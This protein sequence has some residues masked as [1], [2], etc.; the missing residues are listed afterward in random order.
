MLQCSGWRICLVIIV[1]VLYS[2]ILSVSSN[3]TDVHGDMTN[4]LNN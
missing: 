2:T 1:W 4:C 3:I